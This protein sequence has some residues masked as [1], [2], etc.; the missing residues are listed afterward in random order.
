MVKLLVNQQ[1]TN[2][3]DSLVLY[4]LNLIQPLPSEIRTSFESLVKYLKV[5]KKELNKFVSFEC[6]QRGLNKEILLKVLV[7]FF[8]FN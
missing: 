1:Q 2:H 6:E 7:I 4:F 8:C 3:V 5:A